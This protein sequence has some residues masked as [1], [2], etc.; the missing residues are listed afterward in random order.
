MREFIKTK[1]YLFVFIAEIILLLLLLPV[2]YNSI[3]MPS[4][5]TTFYL[6]ESTIPTL[7]ETLQKLGYPTYT[8]D[9]YVLEYMTLPPKGWYRLDGKEEGRFQFF[10]SLHTKKLKT[11]HIRIYA[12]ET[13]VELTKRLANDMKLNAE[14]LLKAYRVRSLYEEADIISGEYEVP[15]EADENDTIDFLFGQSRSILNTF[16]ESNYP[17]EPETEEI[18]VLLIIASIIQKES[19][20]AKEMP[21]ISSVIYNRMHKNM[22][23]QMD[24][25]LNYGKYAH[26]VITPER[27]RSDD[28]A[29]NTYR[30]KGIPPAPLGTVSIEA[31]RA[32]YYPEAGDYLFFMLQKD[33]T[34]RFA[35]TY[36]EH[37]ENIRAFK[38]KTNDANQSKTDSPKASLL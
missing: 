5:K 30:H 38:S 16:I 8:I 9:K 26:T 15:R 22:K 34:H 36:K 28:S 31:L 21:F 14:E 18:R 25:T 35:Q 6:K 17:K 19:N 27:I 33:G 32:A 23:L 2:A 4:A 7:L 29:Y 13:A 37:L 24:G 11:M 1:Y 20:D 3:S 12:G 10:K